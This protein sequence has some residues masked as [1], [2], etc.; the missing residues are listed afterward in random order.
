MSVGAPRSG[1]IIAAAS[2]SLLLLGMAWGAWLLLRPR[3]SLDEAVALAQ[4]HEFEAAEGLVEAR[5]RANPEDPRARMLAAQFLLDR[6]APEGED[7]DQIVAARALEARAHLDAIR[8]DD[9][10]LSALVALYRGTSCFYRDDMPGAEASWVEALRINPEVPQAGWSLLNLYYLQGREAEG[11]SLALRLHEVEPD[12]VDRVQLL[13]ELL[14]QD[15]QPLAAGAIIEKFA[16]IVASHPDDHESASALGLALV[17]E[18]R[19]SEGLTLLRDELQKRPG[20]RRAWVA[21][22]DALDD[23]GEVDLLG[24]TLAQLPKPWSDDPAFDRHRGRVA[25]ESGDWAS[26]AIAYDRAL[27]ND[28]ENARLV[29]RLSRAQRLAGDPLE[30]ERLDT[31]LRR[32]EAAVKEVRDLYGAADAALALGRP[33]PIELHRAIAENRERM[34][35]LREAL[36][37]HLLVLQANADDPSSPEAVDRLRRELGVDDH[38]ASIRQKQQNRQRTEDRGQR[39]EDRGQNDPR[40]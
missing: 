2:W 26:A 3:V 20:D 7:G 4:S 36:R 1:S 21:Y 40:S 35:R 10:R 28:P 6:P 18:S 34:G 29:Y 14:R 9:P 37:W 8:T 23:A 38:R 39:T 27:A 24:R 19:I 13:V 15:A 30:A 31:W 12:P 5:L 17:R 25:Q 33:G 11:R 32:H 16:P 22:L